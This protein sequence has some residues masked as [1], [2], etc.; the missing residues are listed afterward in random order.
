MSDGAVFAE[1]TAKRGRGRPR[2]GEE[3]SLPKKRLLDAELRRAIYRLAV[4]RRARPEAI[5]LCFDVS[6]AT[7]A[8]IASLSIR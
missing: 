7:V 5:A 1:P 3:L 2:K 8:R 4:E 6:V